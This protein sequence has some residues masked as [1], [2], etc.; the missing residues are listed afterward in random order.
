MR[1]ITFAP[2]ILKME[3]IYKMCWLEALVTVQ[4]P[5]VA[6]SVSFHVCFCLCMCVCVYI[7]GLCMHLCACTAPNNTNHTPVHRMAVTSHFKTAVFT[8]ARG[9]L[10][11]PHPSESS[12]LEAGKLFI[13]PQFLD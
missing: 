11:W 3:E 7:F 6:F 2:K 8:E 4:N 1:N 5:H 9:S 13:R 12:E 10:A